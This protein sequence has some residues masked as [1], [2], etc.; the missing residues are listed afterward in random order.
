MV[1]MYLYTAYLVVSESWQVLHILSPHSAW[2][3]SVSGRPH[4]EQYRLL[5]ATD[6]ALCLVVVS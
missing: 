4:D 3:G 2:R 1:Y 5:S 6:I